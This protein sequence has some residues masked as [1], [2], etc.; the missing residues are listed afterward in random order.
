M[1]ISVKAHAA[2]AR[3][4]ATAH[5]PGIVIRQHLYSMWADVAAENVKR[6]RRAR[7]TPPKKDPLGAEMRAALSAICA[8]AFAIEA[9]NR[10][11]R[12]LVKKSLPSRPPAARR[13][14]AA[15][16]LRQTLIPSLTLS[17]KEVSALVAAVKPVYDARNAAVHFEGVAGPPVPHPSGTRSSA[18]AATYSLER[19][20]EAL[21][22]MRAVFRAVADHPSADVQ[23]FAKGH[24]HALR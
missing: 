2:V 3:A 5:A 1:G 10:E 17:Q 19:A 4:T 8:S 18:E 15:Q 14:S 24:A 20:E 22:A 12:P 6:A 13:Q 16:V 23:A 9:L 7:R 21:A 11:L